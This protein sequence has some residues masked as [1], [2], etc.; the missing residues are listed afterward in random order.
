MEARTL[1]C[2]SC[3]AAISSDSTQ[4]RYC[5]ALLQTVSCPSCFALMFKG[6]KF[7]PQCG[8]E[9]QAPISAATAASHT[10]PRCKTA[11]TAISLGNTSLEECAHCGGLWIDARTFERI[12]ADRE[13]QSSAINIKLPAPLPADPEVRYL[14][15]PHCGNLMNRMNYAHCSGVIIDICRPHGIWFDRDQLR[16]IIEFIRAGGMQ[17]ELEVQRQ[18]I[19]EQRRDL[20]MRQAMPIT[21]TGSLLSSDYDDINA[22]SALVGGLASLVSWIFK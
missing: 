16:Q 11:L 6:S 1:N 9:A 21:A 19:Q 15:C 10:C 13:A 14:Q 12:C 20:V 17:R 7:C 4:C 2:P 8:A 18:E 5:Q 22:G 3:G